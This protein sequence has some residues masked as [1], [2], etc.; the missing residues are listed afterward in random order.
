MSL[1]NGL[2]GLVVVVVLGGAFWVSGG[3]NFI[4]P[5]PTP[6]PIAALSELDDLVTASG[7]LLPVK[8][9][10]MSF[11]MIGQVVEVKVKTNDV[12]KAGD[13][14]VRLEAFELEAAVAAARAQLKQLQ[15]GVSKED[16]AVAQANLANAQ[17]QL[18]KV[19]APV[20]VEDV[21]MARAS[22]ERAAAILRDAQSQYDRVRND[23]QVG[24]Y[25]QSQAMHLAT[26]DYRIAEARYAQ[27]SKG[28]TV[29][30]VRIAETAVTVAQ[31]NLERVKVGARAEEIAAAQARLDAALATLNA[32][33][34]TAPFAGTIATMN[35]REGE[36]VTPGVPVLSLGDLSALRLETDDLSETS[37][38]RVKIGQ[39]AVVTFEALPGKKFDGQV[40]AIA[41]IAS[42]KQGGTNYTVTIQV[43]N[44]DAALR[45]GMTGHVEINTKQ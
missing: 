7:T 5:K 40:I 37:I 18:A 25:P 29:E 12:V 21:A 39:R 32:A 17:A 1:K 44:L 36:A 4:A 8:R 43:D 33:T 2:I 42:A 31:A 9:A 30:D 23:P 3:S 15:V 26:Q 34:L 45:W 6:T 11:K 13:V 22:L 16:I 41:P 38:A 24:M 10:N 28:A 19:R 20:A 35:V 14:L 27:V